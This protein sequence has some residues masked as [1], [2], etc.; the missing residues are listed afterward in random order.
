MIFFERIKSIADGIMTFI[1]VSI[2]TSLPILIGKLAEYVSSMAFIYPVSVGIGILFG[3]IS[4][5]AVIGVSIYA[6]EQECSNH[7]FI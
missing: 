7:M 5:F 1:I 2:F 6:Y 3:A 4:V